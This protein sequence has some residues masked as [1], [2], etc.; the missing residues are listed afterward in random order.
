MAVATAELERAAALLRRAERV[1]VLTGAGISA[2][3]GIPT[4]RD[5]GGL[6]AGHV[7]ENVATPRAFHRDP[8]LVWKFY[9]ERRANLRTVV[10]NPG[11]LALVVLE[12]R[13]GPDHFA[14]ITQNVDG[15]HRRAGSRTIHELHGNLARTRCTGCGRIEDRGL[16]PL[17]ELPTCPHCSALLRPDI[18]WFHEMLPTEPWEASETAVTKCDVLIV[19]GTSAV[20]QPASGLIQ[21]AR[22]LGRPVIECNTQETVA[23]SLADV[24]LLGKSGEILP[25]LVE[26]LS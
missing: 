10:P 17:G 25:Q 4:F 5:A 8:K 3:S 2:E 26:L 13:F 7:I 19:V 16:E 18:V 22:T 15:L 21:T 23:S 1:A 12:Q 11:H 9:D 6:W 20:V 24:T 14:V